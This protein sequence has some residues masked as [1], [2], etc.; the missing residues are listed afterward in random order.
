MSLL[1]DYT[2]TIKNVCDIV[3]EMLNE[4]TKVLSM[5]EKCHILCSFVLCLPTF[6]LYHLP[7]YKPL[8]FLWNSSFFIPF[9]QNITHSFVSYCDTTLQYL[10]SNITASILRHDPLTQQD[11]IYLIDLLCTLLEAVLY[12]KIP[13]TITTKDVF[14][15]YQ[16]ALQY[17]SKSLVIKIKRIC[18]L[19]LPLV[20]TCFDEWKEQKEL[21]SLLCQLLEEHLIPHTLSVSCLFTLYTQWTSPFT[22]MVLFCNTLQDLFETHFSSLIPSIHGPLLV[23]LLFRAWSSLCYHATHTL[24]YRLAKQFFHWFLHFSIHFPK[25]AMKEQTQ[26]L[27]LLFIWRLLGR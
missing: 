21:L 27:F 14:D 13:L 8:Q 5:K 3:I 23:Q 22:K 24:S 7:S 1:W 2:T 17:D 12:L 25:G 9:D 10:L 19:L 18:S 26:Y 15:F 20:T 6:R 11:F 4:C 16:R